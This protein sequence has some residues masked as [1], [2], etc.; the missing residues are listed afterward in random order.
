[1][2]FE[3]TIQKFRT[4]DA[5]AVIREVLSK[6]TAFIESKQTEQLFAGKTSEGADI[7]P[8]YKPSTKA[9]KQR[10]G[11]VSDRVT[12][13]DTGKFHKATKADIM[14]DKIEL[15]S[16]DSKTAFLVPKYGSDIFGLTEQNIEA[17]K[18]RVTGPLI[19]KFQKLLL[20]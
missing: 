11:Q 18:E 9:I 5:N 12:L 16:T 1:M 4:L 20:A 19:S 3:K 2:A 13:K 8:A 15:G 14:G 7:T 17:L 10:K 6:E